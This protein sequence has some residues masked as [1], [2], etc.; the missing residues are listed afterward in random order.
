MW[1]IHP[2]A[3][4]PLFTYR[5][6]LEGKVTDQIQTGTTACLLYSLI[7]DSNSFENSFLIVGA[8]P[9]EVSVARKLLSLRQKPP[10]PLMY[11]HTTSPL[12]LRSGPSRF[13]WR[14]WERAEEGRSGALGPGTDNRQCSLLI[15]IFIAVSTI[16]VPAKSWSFSFWEKRISGISESSL[17]SPEL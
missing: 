6:Y 13:Y 8:A 3:P 11:P 9:P 4:S 15:P 14:L 10:P 7:Y 1:V 5:V 2:V 12:S 16:T 17:A